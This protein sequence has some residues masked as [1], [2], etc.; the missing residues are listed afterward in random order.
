MVSDEVVK[1]S[2]EKSPEIN[3]WMGIIEAGLLET[4]L[5]MDGSKVTEVMKGKR[6]LHEEERPIQEYLMLLGKSLG[7]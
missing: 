3:A 2:I 4:Y 7:E 1:P 5:E 6:E